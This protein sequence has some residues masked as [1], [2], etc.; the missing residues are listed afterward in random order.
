MDSEDTDRQEAGSRA[1]SEKRTRLPRWFD[2]A[3]ILGLASFVAYIIGTVWT[4]NYYRG[5][6]MSSALLDLTIADSTAIG[7]FRIFAWMLIPSGLVIGSS[8]AIL[9]PKLYSE[10]LGFVSR[11]MAQLLARR[12]MK[13]IIIAALFILFCVVVLPMTGRSGLASGK[14]AFESIPVA[15]F[16]MEGAQKKARLLAYNDGRYFFAGME[17]PEQ[18]IIVEAS[19]IERLELDLIKN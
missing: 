13:P 16:W 18:L 2:S 12:G 5:L 14:K 17:E 6:G 19:A 10:E 3:V 15:T 7:S 4:Q 9:Y 8:I 11:I 1:D